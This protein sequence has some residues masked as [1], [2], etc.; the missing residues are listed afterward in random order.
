MKSNRLSG[1]DCG[2]GLPVCAPFKCILILARA[3]A[4]KNVIITAIVSIPLD[5]RRQRW[6]GQVR[7]QEGKVSAVYMI[8]R[9]Y[10]DRLILPFYLYLSLSRSLFALCVL[11]LCYLSIQ[12]WA[13]IALAHLE[14]I[15]LRS[16][17]GMDTYSMS[18]FRGLFISPSRLHVFH[19]WRFNRN[20]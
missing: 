6:W 13:N 18:I 7:G 19:Q 10:T 2:L 11:F 9:R 14:F 5:H 17:C 20:L 12:K 15:H 3:L 4:M 8:D 16:S 1:G